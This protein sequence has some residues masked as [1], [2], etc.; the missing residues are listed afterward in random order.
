MS[1]IIATPQGPVPLSDNGG[2]KLPGLNNVKNVSPLPCSFQAPLADLLLKGQAKA[3]TSQNPIYVSY[4]ASP[5]GKRKGDLAISPRAH[6]RCA[7]FCDGDVID[8]D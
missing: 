8:I 2:K 6:K 7:A 3:G 4:V 1:L 5:P